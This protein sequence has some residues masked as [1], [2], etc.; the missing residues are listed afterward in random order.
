MKVLLIHRLS[1]KAA[2]YYLKLVHD[3][4]DLDEERTWE[5]VIKKRQ[6]QLNSEASDR[7]S[8]MRLEAKKR[9][10]EETAELVS[11]AQPLTDE[12]MPD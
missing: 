9:S 4:F 6:E 8:E 7:L 5:L 12:L 10:L 1:S 2:A 11:P 3:L